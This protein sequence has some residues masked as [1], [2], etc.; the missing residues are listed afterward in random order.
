MLSADADVFVPRSLGNEPLQCKESSQEIESPPGLG[1]A[2]DLCSTYVPTDYSEELDTMLNSWDLQERGA[3]EE[4]LFWEADQR[5]SGLLPDPSLDYVDAGTCDITGDTTF[6]M[7]PDPAACCGEADFDLTAAAQ[8]GLDMDILLMD[9]DDIAAAAMMSMCTWG[10]ALSAPA[11]LGLEDPSPC[12]MLPQGPFISSCELARQ[13]APRPEF[14]GD[15]PLLIQTSGGALDG[16]ITLSPTSPAKEQPA[17]ADWSYLPEQSVEG[18]VQKVTISENFLTDVPVK[19]VSWLQDR[20][21]PSP[22]RRPRAQAEPVVGT[23]V[24]SGPARSFPGSAELQ[25]E[26]PTREGG[27][28]GT[29]DGFLFSETANAGCIVKDEPSASVLLTYTEI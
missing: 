18:Y 26:P 29:F 21:L 14:V 24:G 9:V 20:Q 2:D 13:M 19:P 17:E 11:C 5:D 23:A 15:N 4:S 7:W 28:F 10:S 1:Y 12:G 3:C 8:A 27:T 25:Q 22:C 16:L 6:G